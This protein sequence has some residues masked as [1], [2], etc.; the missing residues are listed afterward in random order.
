MIWIAFFNVAFALMGNQANEVGVEQIKRLGK[1]KEP[2]T[3]GLTKP[4]PKA[5]LMLIKVNKK[6]MLTSFSSTAQ[7]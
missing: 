3:S 1:Q 2:S 7:N 4:D 5:R 6:E